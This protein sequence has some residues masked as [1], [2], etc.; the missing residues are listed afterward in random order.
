M[1][2]VKITEQKCETIEMAESAYFGEYR[3]FSNG[4]WF[5]KL[6][7]DWLYVGHN[8]YEEEY[9]RFKERERINKRR[10]AV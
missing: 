5:N 3:R 4:E 9:E 6:G 2:I 7:K 10:K 1:R 8:N